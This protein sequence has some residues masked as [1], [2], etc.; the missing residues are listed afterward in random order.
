MTAHQLVAPYATL[1][2]LQALIN[3]AKE[4]IAQ[5]CPGD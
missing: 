3:R 5:E 2:A 4:Y 1:Q